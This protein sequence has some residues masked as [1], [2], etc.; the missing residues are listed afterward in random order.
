M[1]RYNLRSKV[2]HLLRLPS[3]FLKNVCRHVNLVD[4][5]AFSLTC[6]DMSWLVSEMK[7]EVKEVHV[8]FDKREIEFTVYKDRERLKIKMFNYFMDPKL[9]PH[10][11][12][13]DRHLTVF[14]NTGE[15]FGPTA[16]WNM[17]RFGFQ[18]FLRR[19]TYA[20]HAPVINIAFTHL[21][22]PE[23]RRI[24]NALLE[25]KLG[26]VTLCFSSLQQIEIYLERKYDCF[27]TAIDI[28]YDYKEMLISRL[29][30]NRTTD[31]QS[32]KNNSIEEIETVF[33][34]IMN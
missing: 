21:Q 20:N 8:H 28:H 17:E 6:K 4:L 25:F 32:N 2:P 13:S 19:L 15:T 34:L 1:H 16:C 23:Y 11:H 27:Q 3:D 9:A 10:P 7:I 14:H 24:M 12:P 29:R 31:I 5:Y 18:F 22:K 30:K 33:T 26:T